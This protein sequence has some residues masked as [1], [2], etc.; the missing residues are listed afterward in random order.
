MCEM[1]SINTVAEDIKSVGQQGN[2]KGRGKKKKSQVRKKMGAA[3]SSDFEVCG[4]P[5]P[6][7]Q[8][9]LYP[10]DHSLHQDQQQQPILAGQDQS[11]HLFV[12]K[13]LDQQ[14]PKYLD[15]Q[16]PKQLD[17]LVSEQPSKHIR[18]RS[19][20]CK[21]H[22]KQELE[23]YR[24]KEELEEER[25]KKE[26]GDEKGRLKKEK[27][28]ERLKKLGD[29]RLIEQLE[30]KK[31]SQELLGNQESTDVDEKL[32]DKEPPNSLYVFGVF[33]FYINF[34]LCT[35][36]FNVLVFVLIFICE[37]LSKIDVLFQE[38]DYDVNVDRSLLIRYRDSQKAMKEYNSLKDIE[39]KCSEG[40]CYV[41]KLD[42]LGIYKSF[43]NG[44][45]VFDFLAEDSTPLNEW[46]K[47]KYE[48]FYK[49]EEEDHAREAWWK[50]IKADL[51]RIFW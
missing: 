35:S 32:G 16:L 36:I 10:V 43:E 44:N 17:K 9:V 29:E 47:Q 18:A 37:L 33:G 23:D 42:S 11:P 50:F 31:E 51:R 25:L 4:D 30:D 40:A 19:P 15:Q 28:D 21:L 49:G 1:E 26:K 46:V 8:L 14:L 20:A 24:L 13:H 39:K 48:D 12:D 3:T 2:G 34:Y 7:D 22:K 38:E 41:I 45:E 6:I 5:A 27:E